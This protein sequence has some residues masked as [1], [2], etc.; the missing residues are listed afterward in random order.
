VEADGTVEYHDARVHSIDVGAGTCM[1]VWAD[2][3]HSE[4]AI[5]D[6]QP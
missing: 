5:A 6:V 3:S 1:L 2:G 4:V